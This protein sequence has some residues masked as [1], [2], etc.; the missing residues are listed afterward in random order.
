MTAVATKPALEEMKIGRPRIPGGM[1]VQEGQHRRRFWLKL[2]PGMT[3]EDVRYPEVWVHL[4]R[5]V[6]RHDLLTL[7]AADESWELEVCVEKVLAT[8]VE[9]SA[10]KK[11]GRTPIV[12]ATVPAGDGYHADYSFREGWHIVRQKDGV[13][14]TRNHGSAALA[15]AQFQREQPRSV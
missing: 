1:L 15:I 5:Q 12:A 4:A 8:G 13:I 7:L 2:P 3:D 6:V 11:I 10:R 9:I 14:L